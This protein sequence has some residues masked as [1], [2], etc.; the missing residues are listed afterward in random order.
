MHRPRV[1]VPRADEL[2]G[3]EHLDFT[4]CILNGGSTYAPAEVG[5]RTA[6]ISHIGNIAMQLGR[7]LVWDPDR[8]E[9][10][11]D[12]EANAMLER[13]QRE[14]WSLANIDSWINVG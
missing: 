1:I 8:E 7:P 5:H 9:F 2:K 4:D 14:P 3:G 13:T 10:P 12:A 6:T 11:G